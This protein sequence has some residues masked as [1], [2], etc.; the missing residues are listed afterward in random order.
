[1]RGDTAVLEI[2]G[3]IVRRDSLLAEVF[4][5]TTID[6]LAADFATA[7]SANAVRRILMLID[8]PG[9][10]TAGVWELGEQ[11]FEARG[12]KPIVAY[13]G[14]L[15]GSAAYW[16][17]SA[18]QEIV[19]STT[20]AVGSIGIVGAVHIPEE[21]DRVV[22]VS[23]QSPRKRLDPRTEE[24]RTQL[25]QHVD[26]VAQVFVETV[27][28]NRGVS[29][30]KVLSDFGGGWLKVGRKAVAAGLADRVGNFEGLVSQ[31]VAM[32]TST[33]VVTSRAPQPKAAEKPDF[34]GL[35]ALYMGKGLTR[36][37]AIRRVVEKHPHEHQAYLDRYN[38]EC[39]DRRAAR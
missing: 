24:G 6:S 37:E 18:A 16:L 29:T 21:D 20:A 30:E 2:E 12:G 19:V 27:A 14:S 36:V 8:S 33:Q 35:V 34:D 17:A 5:F 4:G 13:V 22:V 9:G 1:M 15:G 32:S 7:L 26:D 38:A 23:S 31:E 25:Q 11:I 28:R 10:G 3:P 39:G